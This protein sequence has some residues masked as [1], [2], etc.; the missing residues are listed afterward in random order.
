MRSGPIVNVSDR[1]LPGVEIAI[2]SAADVH[3]V[4]VLRRTCQLE[5]THLVLLMGGKL[6]EN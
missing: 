2:C 1:V 4:R 6:L 5:K 3:K